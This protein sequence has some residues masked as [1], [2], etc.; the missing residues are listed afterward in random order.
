MLVQCD[1]CN[2]VYD[3]ANQWTICPHNPLDVGPG[4]DAFCWRCDL[5]HPCACGATAR[6]KENK[7]GAANAS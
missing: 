7:E 1:D 6:A 4:P 2:R 3:D 5:R